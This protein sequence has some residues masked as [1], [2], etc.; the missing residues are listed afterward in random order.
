MGD[1]GGRAGVAMTRLVLSTYG[2][3]CHLR[4]KGCTRIATTKDHLVPYSHGG[5]DVLE[6]YRPACK[7]CNSK[8]QNKVIHGFG[9]SVVVVI[10]PPAGGKTTYIAKHAKA[11]DVAV[12]MDAIARALMPLP[13]ALTHTYP[14]HVR[15]VAIKTRAAAIHAATRLRE[16]VTVW[17]IHAVPRP[18]DLADYRRLGWQVITCDPGRAIVEQRTKAERPLS[19]LAHVARWYAIYGEPDNAADRMPTDPT[20]AA[21]LVASG[22]DPW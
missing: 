17:V 22:A 18:D 19:M 20:E 12:D 3:E 6:N 9:A 4:L 10:G 15:H 2:A 11:N 7:H 8:R 1:R 21:E 5:E 14:D 16:R 13:P